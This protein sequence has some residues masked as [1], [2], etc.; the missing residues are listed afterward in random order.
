MIG[1]A[2]GG[3]RI[4]WTMNENQKSLPAP[5]RRLFHSHSNVS[6]TRSQVVRKGSPH[7]F[8][9]SLIL[10]LFLPA[11]RAAIRTAMA[12]KRVSAIAANVHDNLLHCCWSLYKHR[13]LNIINPLNKFQSKIVQSSKKCCLSSTRTCT[14]LPGLLVYFALP[15]VGPVQDY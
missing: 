9:L 10:F 4:R 6:T 8:P 11:L 12:A 14:N 1:G 15:L 7:F 13:H 5:A 3:C 2:R